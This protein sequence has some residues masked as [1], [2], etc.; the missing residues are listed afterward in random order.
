[1]GNVSSK[2]TNFLLKTQ[3]FCEILFQMQEGSCPS[4]SAQD[5]KSLHMKY[6]DSN[7]IYYK[8]SAP[9]APY[10]SQSGPPV[11]PP[12]TAL[13]VP[14][15]TFVNQKSKKKT[16]PRRRSEATTGRR[17]L[18]PHTVPNSTGALE[19]KVQCLTCHRCR[20]QNDRD[21]GRWTRALRMF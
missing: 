21:R 2:F 11:A 14:R 8:L 7:Y 19:L 17:L 12:S 18:R 20:S 13:A 5:F 1:M 10:L 15:K 6:A 4:P 3:N 16:C 9:P